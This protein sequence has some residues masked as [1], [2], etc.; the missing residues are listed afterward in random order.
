MSLDSNNSLFK[1]GCLSNNDD[2]KSSRKIILAGA[3]VRFYN[4]NV[5][6]YSEVEEDARIEHNKKKFKNP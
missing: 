4:S 5:G 6:E 3:R 2:I 1:K